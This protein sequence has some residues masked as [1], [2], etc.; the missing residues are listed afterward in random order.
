M[1]ENQPTCLVCERTS[2]E[3]PL[4]S[5]TY[6]GQTYWVCPSDLP[7]LIHQPGRL[8]GKLP[9]AEKLRPHEHD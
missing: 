8:I 7:V 9:G 3:V 2:A 1:S 5:V 4:L 6:Q